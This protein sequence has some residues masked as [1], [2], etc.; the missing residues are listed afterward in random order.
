M[1]GQ[2]ATMLLREAQQNSGHPFANVKF[3]I[4]VGG[5][6]PRDAVLAAALEN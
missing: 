1:N 5:F 3:V 2:V 4:L 6:V